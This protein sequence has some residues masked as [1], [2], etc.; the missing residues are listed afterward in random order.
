M[1]EHTRPIHHTTT[2]HRQGKVVRTNSPDL[3]MPRAR[4]MREPGTGYLTIITAKG[5]HTYTEL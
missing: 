2:T 1:I 5:P 3:F 4:P